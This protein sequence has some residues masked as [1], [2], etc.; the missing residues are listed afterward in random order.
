VF[1]AA[2]L[3]CGVEVWKKSYWRRTGRLNYTLAIFAGAGHLWL[4]NHWNLLQSG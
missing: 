2:K 4:L 3:V 1:F